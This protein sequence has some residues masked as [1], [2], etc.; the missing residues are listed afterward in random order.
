[1]YNFKGEP[2]W[3]SKLVC[4]GRKCANMYICMPCTVFLLLFIP[5][6]Y[7][8]A[9]NLSSSGPSHVH[10][11]FTN[12]EQKKDGLWHLWYFGHTFQS[13][14]WCIFAIHSSLVYD[15]T[16]QQSWLRFCNFQT[17]NRTRNQEKMLCL[18][19]YSIKTDKAMMLLLFGSP[20]N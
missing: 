4:K 12:Q 20:L 9:L 10:S 15:T 11:F 1:M 14:L 3:G 17:S 13:R 6:K 2:R 7:V 8:F 16:W 19:S 18:F 5:K